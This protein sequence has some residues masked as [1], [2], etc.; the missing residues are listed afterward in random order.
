[1]EIRVGPNEERKEVTVLGWCFWQY[2]TVVDQTITNGGISHVCARIHGPLLAATATY[3]DERKV[4]LTVAFHA[5]QVV[6]NYWSQCR[7]LSS[8]SSR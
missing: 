6:E 5:H 1:M 8:E 4:L 7:Y 2:G 3:S